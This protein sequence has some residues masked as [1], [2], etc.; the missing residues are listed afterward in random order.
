VAEDNAADGAEGMAIQ[1]NVDG[2]G[3][4][5]REG[6]SYE[7]NFKDGH[8]EGSGVFRWP[9][10]ESFAGEW[11]TDCPRGGTLLQQDGSVRVVTFDGTTPL[12]NGSNVVSLDQLKIVT[13]SGYPFVFL[14]QSL[15]YVK[16]SAIAHVAADVSAGDSHERSCC[17]EVPLTRNRAIA[18][19]Q[20][21]TMAQDRGKARLRA[22]RARQQSQAWS[23]PRPQAL[24]RGS[25]K[26]EGAWPMLR[27]PWGGPC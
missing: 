6:N 23:F 27:T 16:S 19:L 3:R 13:E 21:L 26:D 18:A 11:D 20:S 2:K 24:K 8:F 22:P 10:G 14:S 7:G 1:G 5:E 9:T 12:F 15:R 4:W 25:A 17:L